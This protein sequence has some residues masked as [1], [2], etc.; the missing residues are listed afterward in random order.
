M[1]KTIPVIEKA[2]A[3]LDAIDKNRADLWN[4]ALL[5]THG[6]II[7]SEDEIPNGDCDN[8]NDDDTTEFSGI[9]N[10]YNALKEAIEEEE[11]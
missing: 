9:V 6:C 4:S 10:E 7:W 3:L 1:E 2:K 11:Q 5:D 8:Y